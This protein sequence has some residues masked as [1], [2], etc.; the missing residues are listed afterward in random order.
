MKCSIFYIFIFLLFAGLFVQAQTDSIAPKRPKIGLVLSGG[1]AKGFAHI[2]VLK[3]LEEVGL[4]PDYITGTSMGGILGGFYALGFS[5]DSIAKVVALQD[6]ELLMNDKIKR[7]DLAFQDKENDERYVLTL[8]IRKKGVD[9]PSGIV[10][11]QR[12]T[13]FFAEY[14]AG[15]HDSVNFKNFPIPFSCI[16]ADIETGNYYVMEKGYLPEALRATMSI[17]SVFKPV[18]FDGRLLVDGG[19]VNNFPVAEVKKMGADIVIGVDVQSPYFKREDLNSILRIVE[20][21]SKF[22]RAPMNEKNR[23]MCDIYLGPGIEEYSI[24]SF[25]QYDSII[26]KIGRASCRERV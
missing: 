8:P 1:G 3:V 10:S 16:A 20:Q 17:P 2:G 13:S 11:G 15:F 22:L 18:T 23:A 6:W 21:S 24:S 7:S 9:L 26:A 25:T 19:L 12:V 4:Q 14:C 5:A